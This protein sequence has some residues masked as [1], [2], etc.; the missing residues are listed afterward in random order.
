[1]TASFHDPI[2]LICR[3]AGRQTGAAAAAAAA[4]PAAP[5]YNMHVQLGSLSLLHFFHKKKINNNK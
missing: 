2:R 1:M 3:Q 4:A 5:L